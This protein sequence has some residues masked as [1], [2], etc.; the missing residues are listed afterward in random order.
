MKLKSRKTHFDL[1]TQKYL[2]TTLVLGVSAFLGGCFT[3]QN[4]TTMDEMQKATSGRSVSPIVEAFVQYSGPAEKWAGPSGFVFHVDAKDP[5]IAQVRFEPTQPDTLV[6]WNPAPTPGET[7][8]Q[9]VMAHV[10]PSLTGLAREAASI[11]Q[12]A[13]TVEHADHSRDRAPA[14]VG[15]LIRVAGDVA[16]DRLKQLADITQS[17]EIASAVQG[18]LNPI[19]VRLIRADGTSVERA[20]CRSQQGWPGQTSRWLAQWGSASGADGSSASAAAEE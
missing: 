18:C 11:T 2:G 13:T 7:A 3:L 17:R 10:P 12:G 19:H 4:S 1:T 8:P 20:G 14:A 5:G 6:G 9:L 15:E 16:R